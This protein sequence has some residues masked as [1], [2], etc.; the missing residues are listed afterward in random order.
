M[1]DRPEHRVEVIGHGGAGAFFPGNSRQSIEQ[2]LKIGVDRIEFDVQRS[3]DGDLVLVHD[4]HLRID[5]GQKRAVR[6]LKA[7]ELRELLTGLLT[8]DEAIELIGHNAAILIDVKAPS[9]QQL[10]IDAIRRHNLGGE[11]AVSS[12]YA[13][14]LR[15]IRRA[16]SDIRIGIST[17]HMANALPVKSARTLV[18]GAL[19]ISVPSV[20]AYAVRAIGATDVMIQHRACSP[21]LVRQMHA[22]GIKVNTWTVDQPK[23]I[24][25]MIAMGV[26]GVISNRP[27]LVKEALDRD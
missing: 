16:S 17:G 1:A 8:I 14:V 19:Q 15:D 20:L 4:D 13:N 2:A 12:T 10:V 26:D 18:S 21:R 27:D 25:R 11:T 6:G 23:Q 22:R 3:A 9:Y 24:R 5:G 7:A